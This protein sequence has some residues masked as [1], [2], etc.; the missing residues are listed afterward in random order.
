MNLYSNFLDCRF[1]KSHYFLF[2][3]SI[4]TFAVF[5]TFLVCG[6]FCLLN[7]QFLDAFP[8]YIFVFFLC[9]GFSLGIVGLLFHYAGNRFLSLHFLLRF[10][11]KCLLSKNKTLLLLF[12]TGAGFGCLW[13]YSHH[14][15]DH[16]IDKNAP[17]MVV[18]GL[19]GATWDIIEPLFKENK[20][21]NIKRLC[22]TGVH[23][24]LRSLEPMYSPSLWTSIASGVSPEKHGVSG[25]FST[26]ADLK[27]PRVW[28]Y[29]QQK[30]LKTG[31]FSWI[32][33][34]PPSHEFEFVMPSWF[35]P[36]P[37]TWPAEYSPF[38]EL[39]LEQSLDGGGLNPWSDILKN[40]RFGA[41]LSSINRLLDF[42]IGDKKGYTEEQRLIR[43]GNGARSSANGCLPVFV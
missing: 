2:F 16:R 20:L 28:E 40:I 42:Y 11:A 25:F 34:W 24:N 19:D 4:F 22:E 27:V 6:Y 35:S 21:K 8:G 41:R 7:S 15:I 5:F 37:D 14:Q 26:Q 36:K 12:I 17:K 10:N 32:V 33:T 38:Q 23:G 43:R 29:A 13:L 9:T 18:L 30:G 3:S 39:F 31:L 1:W